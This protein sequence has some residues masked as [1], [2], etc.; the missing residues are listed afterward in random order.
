MWYIA[1][2]FWI[3]LDNTLESFILHSD[4]FLA[5]FDAIDFTWTT[6]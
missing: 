4:Y 6:T 3:N 2:S 5:Y 1:A